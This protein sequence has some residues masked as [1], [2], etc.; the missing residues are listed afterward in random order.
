MLRS[1]LAFQLLLFPLAGTA[2]LMLRFGGG[3]GALRGMRALLVGAVLTSLWVGLPGPAPWASAPKPVEGVVSEA[4]PSPSPMAA[5]HSPPPT[6]LPAWPTWP[7]ALLPLGAWA[8]GAGALRRR[9]ARTTP[10]RTLAGVELRAGD[11]SWSAWLPGRRVVVFDPRASPS[12]QQ[13]TL[14]HE[15]QHHRQGDPQWA[16][17]L[18]ALQVLCVLNPAAHLLARSLRALE[19]LAC[20]AALMARG[21]SAKRYGAALLRAASSRSGP[22]AIAFHTPTL[23]E[24]RLTLLKKANM[25]KKEMTRRAGTMRWILA[26]GLLTCGSVA[27]AAELRVPMVQSTAAFTVPEHPV[28]DQA[29]GRLDSQLAGFL[30]EG[31][32]RYP[33]WAPMV[34]EELEAWGLPPELAAVP[35]I[36]S[37]YQNLGTHT[38][39]SSAAPGVPGKGLWMFIPST[40]RSYGLQVEE[41]QDQRLNPVLETRAAAALLTDLYQEFGDWGLALAGYNQGAFHVRNAIEVQQTED[42]GTLVERG[43]LNPYSSL[44]FAASERL[45]E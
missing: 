13:L 18:F 1:F 12:D 29:R 36:E 9:V 15:L 33:Q 40:A 14:R 37:G 39:G 8:C 6:P 16:W 25:T 32:Q 3:Q 10:L 20:D 43:A 21:T 22:L 28:M 17:L 30:S 26:L 31:L 27:I 42:W 34:H 35:L 4:L 44:V 38:P 45:P 41:G 7:L 23:L 11:S 5:V 24:G 2:W 19:E